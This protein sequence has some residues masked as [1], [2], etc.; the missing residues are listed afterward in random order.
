LSLLHRIHTT[1]QQPFSLHSHLYNQQG[2]Y[3]F[4][5]QA[6][7]KSISPIAQ[8]QIALKKNC[9]IIHISA[10]CGTQ[11]QILPFAMNMSTVGDIGVLSTICLSSAALSGY[12]EDTAARWRRSA[13]AFRQ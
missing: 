4:G 5:G 3:L 12:P 11:L 13:A 6:A 2:G 1:S 9:Y 10:W 8:D 7:G